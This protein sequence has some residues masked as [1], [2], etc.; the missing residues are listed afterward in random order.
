MAGQCAR[1][2]PCTI[3]GAVSFFEH[4]AGIPATESIAQNTLF[5]NCVNDA[6]AALAT[7]ALGARKASPLVVQ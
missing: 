2:V 7:G 6:K 5:G 3:A 1:T 4:T